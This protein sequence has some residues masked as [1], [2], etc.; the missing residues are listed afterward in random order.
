[1]VTLCGRR[2]RAEVD[3]VGGAV[4][5]AKIVLFLFVVISRP[6][7]EARQSCLPALA[8]FRLFVR[9]YFCFLFLGGRIEPL[10]FFAFCWLRSRVIVIST[11]LSL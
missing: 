1:V 11:F 6:P 3:A 9:R 10:F 2:R 8:R 7:A 4:S 5:C